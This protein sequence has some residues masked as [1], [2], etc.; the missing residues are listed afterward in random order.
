L[1]YK[2]HISK[3]GRGEKK[4]RQHFVENKTRDYAACLKNALNFLTA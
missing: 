1:V 2:T 3:G 4:S